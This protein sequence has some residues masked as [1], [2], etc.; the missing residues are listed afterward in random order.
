MKYPHL[1]MLAALVAVALVCTFSLNSYY[2]FVLANVALI[3]IVGVGLNILL[4]LS[5]QI[6]F[7]HVGFYAIG[8]YT[9]AVLTTQ[10]GWSFWPAWLA[11]A[12][13]SGIAGACHPGNLSE[14]RCESCPRLGRARVRHGPEGGESHDSLYK[15]NSRMHPGRGVYACRDPAHRV[16]PGRLRGRRCEEQTGTNL[17]I[18]HFRA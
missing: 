2:V 15:K 11:G 12:L 14:G 3:T 6:S 8:A 5:G 10:A 17:G 4:G 18:F 7:G 1:I 16:R 13:F 9:V